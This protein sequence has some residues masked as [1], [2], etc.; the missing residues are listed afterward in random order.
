[1]SINRIQ[2][3]SP[4]D[5]RLITIILLF[6]VFAVVI[7]IWNV[8]GILEQSTHQKTDQEIAYELNAI[9][10][11]PPDD[12]S[13]EGFENTTMESRQGWCMKYAQLFWESNRDWSIISGNIIDPYSHQKFPHMFNLN[14][15]ETV[16]FEPVTGN[17][18][19]KEGYF[20]I[21]QVSNV[22]QYFEYGDDPRYL[23]LD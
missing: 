4:K 19:T 3:K 16:V 13:S 20:R 23:L 22:T 11:Y 18:Y 21:Y 17:F 10:V 9:R 14:Y 7:S 6:L 12:V 1:M 15:D 2:K 8:Q 5:W